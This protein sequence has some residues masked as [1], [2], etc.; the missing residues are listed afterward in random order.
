[1]AAEGMD[2][3]VTEGAPAGAVGEGVGTE[4]AV[5]EGAATWVVVMA[6]GFQPARSSTA[7]VEAK[8]RLPPVR[9]LESSNGRPS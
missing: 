3:V 8:N 4:G 5:K 7:P 9:R 2:G 1:M 6:A